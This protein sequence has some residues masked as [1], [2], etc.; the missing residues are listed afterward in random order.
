MKNWI[1]SH[2]LNLVTALGGLVLIYTVTAWS[3]MPVLQRFDALFFLGL[4]LHLWE[5]GRYPGGFTDLVTSK[6]KFTQNNPHFG[7]LVTVTIVLLL[8]FVPLL[9]PHVAFLS[10]A[11]LLV[12]IL[13][14]VAHIAAAVIMLR[15]P[16][17]PG[18]VSALVVLLPITIAGDTYAVR[19]DLMSPLSWLFAFL[20]MF[21]AL[22][23]AQQIV[24]RASGMKYSEFLRNVREAFF[25]KC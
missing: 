9:F 21:A 11:A 8:T 6:L 15:R 14:A 1:I 3:A 10:M 13:E 18:M 22:M 20:Y 24:V 16:Y 4:I 19:H 23:V 17:S 2:I 12:G 5:E 25:S 7:E